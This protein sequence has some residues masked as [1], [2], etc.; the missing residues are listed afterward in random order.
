[1]DKVQMIK[2]EIRRRMSEAELYNEKW[3]EAFE[4]VRKND[5]DGGD[6]ELRMASQYQAEFSALKYLLQYIEREVG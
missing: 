1:M 3:L 6:H 2:E 5:N 4:K